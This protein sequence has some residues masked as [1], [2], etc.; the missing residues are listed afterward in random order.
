VTP[1]RLLRITALVSL[2]LIAIVAPRTATMPALILMVASGIAVPLGLGI[3]LAPVPGKPAPFAHH[4]IRFV[5]PVGAA[6]G[7]LGWL[8]D[9]GSPRAIAGAAA[10]ALPC[11]VAGVLAIERIWPMLRTKKLDPLPELAI[12]VGLLF[13]PAAAVWLLA[14]R[15]GMPLA[16]FQEPVVTFTAAHFHFAGFAAPIVLGGVGRMLGPDARLYRIGTLAVCAGVPLTAIGIATNHTVEQ[17]SAVTVASGML[18]ASI[19]LVFYA[20]PIA[21]SFLGRLL[22]IVAGT[23]LLMTMALA[24]T[25]ALTSSAGRGSSLEGAVTVQTMID[26]HGAMNA[27]AFACSAL[28]AL[29]LQPLRSSAR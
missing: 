11:F 10:H 25:F 17:I 16:G 18:C 26:F 4:L 5:A 19:V 24:A 1:Q 14:S 22:F 2:A 28:V 13:L 21:T 29:T 6:G 3:A 12:D 23:S 20:S 15:A 9:P 7:I 27:I 8:D